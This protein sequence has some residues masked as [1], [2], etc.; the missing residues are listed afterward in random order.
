[1]LMGMYELNSWRVYLQVTLSTKIIKDAAL[2][3]HTGTK[4][5]LF[6]IISEN[7]LFSL[8]IAKARKFPT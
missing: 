1:M 8:L 6:N 4:R 2:Y 3:V 7:N 5:T